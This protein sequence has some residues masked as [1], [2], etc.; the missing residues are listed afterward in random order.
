MSVKKTLRLLD[1]KSL[2][3]WRRKHLL[4]LAHFAFCYWKD[5]VLSLPF[6]AS[7]ISCNKIKCCLHCIS[8]YRMLQRVYCVFQYLSMLQSVYCVFQCL[9]YAS[10]CLLCVSVFIVCFKVFIVCFSVY[11]MLQSIY[12]MFQCLLYAS[13]CWLCFSV[14]RMLQSVYCVFQCL[15]CAGV[16]T[17]SSTCARC[18]A[19]F[20][21]RRRWS[22][23]PLSSR[24]WR[25]LTPP[26]TQSSTASSA[27]E[28]VNISGNLLLP[29]GHR[30]STP[31]NSFVLLHL[32]LVFISMRGVSLGFG[33][34]TVRVV[35][36]DEGRL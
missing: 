26:P 2:R 28:Y 5:W 24:A 35:F 9:S 4:H 13:K 7:N 31:L 14:Y 11:L 17:S 3:S 15:S 33:S 23:C 1:N 27:P 34:E 16:P 10:K 12:C 22:S 29:A 30:R 6:R 21:T 8:I 25:R 18:T 32:T 19:W 36:R 20:P